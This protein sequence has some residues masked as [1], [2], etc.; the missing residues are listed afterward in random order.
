MLTSSFQILSCVKGQKETESQSYR[1]RETN[2]KS[3]SR[4]S[5]RLA[6]EKHKRRF[7]QQKVITNVPAPDH[8]QSFFAICRFFFSK[9]N[10]IKMEATSSQTQLEL[11]FNNALRF[12][13][14]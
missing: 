6:K 10:K 7:P 4:N 3:I 9:A 5:R 2:R 13:R 12:D 11:I 8:L 1:K 14:Q